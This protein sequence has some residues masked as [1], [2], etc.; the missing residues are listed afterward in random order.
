MRI[1]DISLTLSPDS[2]VWPGDPKV[3]LERF[4][5][6]IRGDRSNDT[7]L[8]CSVHTG[9]HVDAPLHVMDVGLGVADLSLD[10][11]VGPATVA[12]LRES[13]VVGRED[14]EAL[15]LPPGTKRLLL[16][17]RNSDFWSNPCH[18][19]FP[20]FV[21]LSPEGAH[22]AVK[23]GLFL[24]GI[25]Y[26]SIQRFSEAGGETHQRLLEAGIVILEGLNLKDVD[27]GFYQ[28]VCLPLKLAKSDGSP[29]RA[30]LIR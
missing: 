12:E 14:L 29:A 27:P 2:P 19:F 22:W 9:T 13:E 30:I 10:K 28:L 6:L 26:L 18:E 23:K 8:A 7:R 4:R 25:D 21:A 5:A 3:S 17:T 16:K 11:L 24:I 1:L 15:K 20:D